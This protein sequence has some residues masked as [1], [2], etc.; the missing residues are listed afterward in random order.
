MTLSEGQ[1]PYIYCPSVPLHALLHVLISVL[2]ALGNYT[3][4]FLL[5]LVEFLREIRDMAQLVGCLPSI[6]HCI[7]HA[8]NPNNWEESKH[9]RIRN[10]RAS[11]AL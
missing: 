2:L 11:S 4:Q 10:S 3:T 6:Q 7:I 8:Y 1:P 5:R 9:C